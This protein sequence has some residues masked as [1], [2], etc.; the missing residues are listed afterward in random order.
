M[1]FE[2]AIHEI[3]NKEYQ[4]IEIDFHQDNELKEEKCDL[5]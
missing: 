5:P 4:Q 3:I 1:I 2:S